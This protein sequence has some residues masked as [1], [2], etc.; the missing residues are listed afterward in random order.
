MILSRLSRGVL[1]RVTHRQ[2]CSQTNKD[3]V[4]KRAIQR[5]PLLMQSLQVGALMGGGDLISQLV[6]EKKRQDQLNLKRTL[7]F[8]SM[9]LLVVSVDIS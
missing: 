6:I 4:Y 2:Y 8:A 3:G 5:F 9:G 7:Q 1:V